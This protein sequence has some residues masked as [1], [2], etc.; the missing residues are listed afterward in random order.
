MALTLYTY[1]RS[2]ASYRVRIA[3]NLKGVSAQHVA[4]NIAPAVSEQRGEAYRKINPAMRVPALSIDGVTLIQSMAMLEWI[5]EAYPAPAVLPVDPLQRAA[6]RA[7]AQ[8]ITSDIHPIQNMTVL[9]ALRANHGANDEGV[10]DWIHGVMVRGFDALEALAQARPDT[11][12]MF[13][14]TPTFA[15]ICLV[16][17]MFNARRFEVSLEPYR[18]L[19]E[20]DEAARSLPAFQDAA[21]ENQPDASVA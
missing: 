16:P 14:E 5:E 8:T 1:W 3:L 4:V 15:E 12:F 7:F 10:R 21:P 13:G 2:S 17:Q 20:I 9:N 11:Q 18:R 19:C 6:C